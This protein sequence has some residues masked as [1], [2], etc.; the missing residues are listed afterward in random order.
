M[1]YHV[2]RSGK[3]VYHCHRFWLFSCSIQP[4][5]QHHPGCHHDRAPILSGGDIICAMFIC[6]SVRLPSIYLPIHGNISSAGSHRH[7]NILGP[8]CP[9]MRGSCKSCYSVDERYL[10]KP[11][12]LNYCHL[13]CA[14][15]FFLVAWSENQHSGVVMLHSG[16]R[17]GRIV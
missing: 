11:L 6:P 9:T 4:H 17:S 16:A 15:L 8:M 7:T 12:S 14:V 3:P 5:S 13:Y 2:K 10:Q 1:M